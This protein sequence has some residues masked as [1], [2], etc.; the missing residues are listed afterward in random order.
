MAEAGQAAGSLRQ[1]DDAAPLPPQAYSP[2]RAR[3]L[4][5]LHFSSIFPLER[6]PSSE[7]APRHASF[8]NALASGRQVRASFNVRIEMLS[9]K[10]HAFSEY[11]IPPGCI[12]T[13]DAV[14]HHIEQCRWRTK[15]PYQV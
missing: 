1:N 4:R 13:A 10:F 9:Q 15:L 14:R 12:D 6:E 3:L 5:P 2:R 8:Q 11:L 7:R